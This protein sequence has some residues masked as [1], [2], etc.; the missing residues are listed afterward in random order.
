MDNKVLSLL[1]TCNLSAWSRT[2]PDAALAA[3]YTRCALSLRHPRPRRADRLALLR[4]Y[5][6]LPA[7]YRGLLATWGGDIAERY[8]RATRG[9]P[10]A[11]RLLP[12]QPM[13]GSGVLLTCAHCLC[14]PA[15]EDSDEDDD[16]SDDEEEEGGAAAASSAAARA[17]RAAAGDALRVGR[18]QVLV[19]P[20]GEFSW[21]RALPRAAPWTWRCCASR[22]PAPRWPAWR[23]F[24]WCRTTCQRA[25]RL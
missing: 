9:W 17:S 18:T 5:L 7:R 14:G 1:S 21:P 25:T 20:S 22:P 4:T 3:S 11:A 6:V 13:S 23:T 2:V 19:L 15:G 10:A 12:A 24:P 8:A 16:D